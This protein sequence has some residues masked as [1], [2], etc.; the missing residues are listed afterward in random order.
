MIEVESR[1]GVVGWSSGCNGAVVVCGGWFCVVVG[2]G[3]VVLAGK[4]RVN[5]E[6][7]TRSEVSFFF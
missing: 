4:L 1:L 6:I 2:I 3:S 5:A 7:A